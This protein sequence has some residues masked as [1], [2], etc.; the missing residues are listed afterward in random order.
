MDKTI[1]TPSVLASSDLE[2]K[3]LFSGLALLTK[4]DLSIG[5]YIRTLLTAFMLPSNG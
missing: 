5:A 1:L 2:K 4:H 3:I